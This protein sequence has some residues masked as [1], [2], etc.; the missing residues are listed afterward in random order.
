MRHRIVVALAPLSVA[1][2][3]LGA[4]G[5]P[6]AFVG[7]SVVDVARGRVEADQTVLVEGDRIVRVGRRGQVQLPAGAR[8][9][10]GRGRF[11][12]PGL[13]DMHV[14][15]VWPGL[16]QLFLPLLVANGI[17]GIRDM[18]SRIEWLDSARI[19]IEGGTLVGPRVVG[20]GNL[21]D[22]VPQIG[23]PAP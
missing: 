1:S 13:W 20:S 23:G 4:Q 8:T 5:A 19:S 14:H 7:V 11:L 16:Q 15:A 17:T 9:I 3:P 10:E 18:W 2:F 21:V 12:I 6:I 22:G